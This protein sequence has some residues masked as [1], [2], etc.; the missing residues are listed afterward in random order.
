MS[1]EPNQ[2]PFPVVFITDIWHK[3]KTQ[4]G[5]LHVASLGDV[6]V[7]GDDVVLMNPES[8]E[9]RPFHGRVSLRILHYYPA[10]ANERTKINFVEVFV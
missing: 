8:E 3:N 10:V 9:G 6:P 4:V 1:Y 7:V 2:E 5:L